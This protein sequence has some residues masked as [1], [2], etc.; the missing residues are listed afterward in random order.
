MFFEAWGAKNSLLMVVLGVGYLVLYLAKREEKLLQALGY[1]LGT[2][3]I[4]Y[5]GF[6]IFLN[7]I[8]APTI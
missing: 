8:G 2:V 3:I 7:L 6:C 4:L 5:S 1:F